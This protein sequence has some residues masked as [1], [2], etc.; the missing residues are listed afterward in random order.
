L[1]N[2]SGQWKITELAGLRHQGQTEFWP[3]GDHR[4]GHCSAA[5]THRRG[6]SGPAPAWFLMIQ[7]RELLTLLGGAAGWPLPS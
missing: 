1:W 7:G 3:M 2:A 6:I 4:N 5:E